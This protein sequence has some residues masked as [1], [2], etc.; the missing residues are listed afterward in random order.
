VYVG[1]AVRRLAVDNG[2]DIG[3]DGAVTVS[4]VVH[5][6]AELPQRGSVGTPRRS[7]AL[8]DQECHQRDGEQRDQSDEEGDRGHARS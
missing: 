1:G 8:G 3:R 7:P 2:R 6:G 5:A 4:Q